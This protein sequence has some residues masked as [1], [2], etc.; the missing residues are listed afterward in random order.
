VRENVELVT[1]IADNPMPADEALGLSDWRSGWITFPSQL[2]GGDSSA[3]PC[4]RHVKRPEVLLCDE[5]TG[6][7]G[8]RD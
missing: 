6:A 5:P 8:L 7:L 1:D 2:S 4:A 3:W